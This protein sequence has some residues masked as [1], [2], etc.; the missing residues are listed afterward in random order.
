MDVNQTQAIILSG[1]PLRGVNANYTFYHDETN[2]IRKFLLTDDGLNNPEP[3]CFVLGGVVYRSSLK[4]DWI[5]LFR[6]LELQA[7]V[8]ELKLKHLGKGDFLE[9]LSSKKLPTL[10]KWLT[11]RNI[12][13]HFSAVDIVYWSVVDIIDSIL[14]NR[15]HDTRVLHAR[16]YKNLLYRVLKRDLV[17]TSKMLF[18][19]D[20]PD[21]AP[22]ATRVFLER[23]VAMVESSGHVLLPDEAVRL[24]RLLLDGMDDAVLEFIQD[25]ERHV[26]ISAFDGFYRNVI[27][28]YKDSR[29]FLDREDVIAERLA[30]AP[31]KDGDAPYMGYVFLDSK[32]D[33]GI[34][35]ADVVVGLLG[36]YWTYVNSTDYDAMVADMKSLSAAQ[37]TTVSALKRAIEASDRVSDGFLHTTI[38]DDDVKKHQR[39][40][41]GIA[42][43]G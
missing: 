31:L 40:F 19:A 15:L 37:R 11:Q 42:P 5:A 6:S 17:L 33:P 25:E 32:A 13:I 27:C 39:F 41:W 18:S 43:A 20:Y 9:L 30:K 8:R 7:S 4:P 38:C 26:L 22:G 1:N 23:L 34:Q 21:I 36:K 16:E 12:H 29:H 24:T 35:V 14:V 10:L 2:N 3:K 28:L